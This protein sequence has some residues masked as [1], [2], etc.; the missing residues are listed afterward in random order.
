MHDVVNKNQ[1]YRKACNEKRSYILIELFGER[2]S[3]EYPEGCL[4]ALYKVR[5][6]KKAIE[7]CGGKILPTQPFCLD[8][9]LRERDIRKVNSLLFQLFGAVFPN[10]TYKVLFHFFSYF[11]IDVLICSKVI[12]RQPDKQGEGTEKCPWLP[13]GSKWCPY[14]YTRVVSAGSKGPLSLQPH[15]ESVRWNEVAQDETDWHS[16]APISRASQ[17][18]WGAEPPLPTCVS[19]MERGEDIQYSASYQKEVA[20][21]FLSAERKEQSTLNSIPIKNVLQEQRENRDIFI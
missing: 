13:S 6:H 18:Q 16:A 21:H 3:L 7:K 19:K 20:Q 4:S 14:S 17:A 8:V 9:A 1:Q 15:L 5:R 12:L 11:Q 10:Q 2:N